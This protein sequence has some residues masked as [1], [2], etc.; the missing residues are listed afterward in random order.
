NQLLAWMFPYL[1]LICMA[2]V[3]TG[4]LNARGRFFI[5]A[6]TP[7][8][9]NLSLLAAILCYWKFQNPS[10]LWLGM[11]VLVGGVLQLLLL[12]FPLVRM[13]GLPRFSGNPLSDPNLKSAL[14][15]FLPATFTLGVTQI[16]LL[17]NTKFALDMGEGPN[18]YL[19]YANRLAELPL[20]IFGIAIATAAF[21]RFS[22]SALEEDRAKIKAPLL[23]SLTGT[24]LVNLPAMVGLWVLATPLVDLLFNRGEFAAR[25]GLEGTVLPLRVYVL[26]LISFTCVKIFGNLCYAVGDARTPVV[27]GVCS[28]VTNLFLA[29]WLRF[30]WLGHSGIALAV[31]CGATVNVLVMVVRL[32]QRI[33][34]SW[35]VELASPVGRIAVA[36]ILMGG[37]VHLALDLIPEG[38]TAWA[39]STGMIVGAVVYSGL[40]FVMFPDRM[41][42][43]LK[44]IKKT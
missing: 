21:P 37:A 9:F 28:V 18:S 17:V 13:K 20:G 5:P 6:A 11:G 41:K 24:F 15:L 34:L 2:A 33:E 39:V 38:R 10:I 3:A 40:G 16:N 44:R 29:Y 26:G 8:L 36:S 14:A 7:I 22:T 23:N 30:T 19:F 1:I 42:T 25:G 27:A 31:V 32:R 43:L 35:L 12:V 4:V